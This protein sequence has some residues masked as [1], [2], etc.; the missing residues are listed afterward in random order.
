MRIVKTIVNSKIIPT[1]HHL[2]DII[3]SCISCFACEYECR[4]TAN[5]ERQWEV[6]EFAAYQLANICKKYSKH[7]S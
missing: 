4:D 5:R 2:Y 6:R 3:Q 1:D 7:Y